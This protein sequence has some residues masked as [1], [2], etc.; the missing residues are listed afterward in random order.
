MYA[1]MCSTLRS[2]RSTLRVLGNTDAVTQV[3]CPSIVGR[4]GEWS[5]L[6]QCLDDSAVGRGGLV[7]VVG[8][9]GIGKTR[10]TRDLGDHAR[11]GG[12]RVLLGRAVET[13][14]ATPFRALFEAL[15]GYFRR[16][17]TDAH[18]ELERLRSTLALLV[19]EWRVPGEEPYRASPMELG[20]ALVRLLTGIAGQTGCVL[21]LEDLHWGDPDTAA[22]VE[23]LGD[24][25][26]GTRVLCV[27]T[28]RPDVGTPALRVV[29]ELMGR[30][31]ARRIELQRLTI[32]ETMAMARLCLG[33]RELPTDIDA[34]VRDFSDGLPFLVEELMASAVDTGSIVLGAEGWRIGRGGL[35]SIPPRFVE[36]VRR[37]MAALPDDAAR[38]LSAAVVL[39]PRIDPG[40]LPVV[41][42]LSGDR[43][44]TALRLGIDH[45]LVTTDPAD[46]RQFVFR[47]ALTRDA[48]L[49]LLLPTELIEVSRR[50]FDAIERH[51]P[52]FPG[53]MCELAASLAEVIDDHLRAAELWLLA[54]RRAYET[55]AM[56]SS[57]PML[58]RAWA[59]TDPSQAIWHEIGRVL[60]QV[61]RTSGHVDQALEVGTRL[62]ASSATP[63][64][65]MHAQ[66]ELARA[67]TTAGRWDEATAHVDWA[68]RTA[69]TTHNSPNALIDLT[70]AEIAV[71]RGRFDDARASAESAALQA[72]L[73]SDH[74]LVAEAWLVI[75]RCA[76]MIDGSDPAVAFDRV[77][78]IGRDHGL[79][80]L[81]L[82]G[83]MERAS[84]DCWSLLPVDRLLA[85]R[86]RAAAVGALVDAAHLD[87]LLAWTARDRWLPDD[88]DVAADRCAE[89]A[90]K[91]HLDVLH[92]M[93]LGAGAAA[94]G[95]RGDRERMEAK[96]AAALEVSARHPDV[97][98]ACA[99]ARVC[100][101][102][103]RDDLARVSSALDL[104]MGRLGDAA[105]I[106]GPE[107][108]LWTLLRIIEQRGTPTLITDLEASPAFTL[109]ANKA[110]RSYA[111]AVMAGRAG[112]HLAAAEHMSD[113][114]RAVTPL[115]WFQHHAR[116]LIAETALADGWGDPI[117]WLRDAVTYFEQQGPD[118]LVSTCRAMLARA[119][120]PAPRR[121]RERGH[122]VP[123]D[124]LAAGI[125]AREVEVLERLAAAQSTKDIAAHLFL[126]PKT[127]ERH[128]S[129]LAVKLGLGGRAALVAFAAAR[130]ARLN[131]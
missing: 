113:G 116:R 36:L 120:A 93:A 24:N 122:D 108:G 44:I 29:T 9:V 8:E 65:E 74:R 118:Q 19:P 60:V 54:G 82:R 92:G 6:V 12:M 33:G 75:G 114:D 130:A 83:E 13:G 26:T 1:T 99:M 76:R 56:S 61:L 111:L 62:L 100:L 25:L 107:R 57:A 22:V 101:S 68:L 91:L 7:A 73:E 70:A 95:Q 21:I 10:L 46:D 86:E 124:L 15:S 43:T 104:A 53:A 50:A 37:R 67:A 20:E 18:P 128:I 125:T 11:S 121:T 51:H 31:S 131:R 90:G 115:T 42:G 85:V 66:L 64:D 129:N 110:Y 81:A 49:S 80:T 28:L 117:S 84:L 106:G 41:T 78:A 34:Y 103:E 88:V 63:F 98:A 3:V 112:D 52:D 89:L 16:A 40:L 102:L 79:T 5:E 48:V 30:H 17:G 72:E 32:D 58:E 39:G 71:G 96:I 2:Q 45:Q 77:I 38:V 126:S 123:T 27:V 127:V 4:D 59:T 55:G 119:G 87:N 94:A 105:A 69:S 35:P 97:A 47:H 14:A 23:Y 109:V